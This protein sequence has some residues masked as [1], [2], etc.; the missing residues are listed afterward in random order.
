MIIIGRKDFI[1]LKRC[2]FIIKMSKISFYRK[3]RP[4]KFEDIIGQEPVIET[5]QGAIKKNKI[6][7]AYIFSGPRGTGKTSTARILAKSLNCQSKI[8]PC[9]KCKICQ[10]I[11]N[12]NSLD[13]I[14][15]DA[16]SHRGIEEIKEIISKINFAPSEGE[17]KIFIIDEAHMLTKEAFNV[18][19]KTLEEPPA[20]AIFIL[21]TT[22]IHKIIPTIISRCQGLDFKKLN[23]EQIKKYLK[24]IVQKEKISIDENALEMLANAADGSLRDA[25]SLLDQVAS[26]SDKKVTL[27]NVQFSLGLVLTDEIINL[28]LSIIKNQPQ[29]AIKIISQIADSGYDL[30]LFLKRII[31][32][33][34]RMYLIQLGSSEISL[35][36][37]EAKFLHENSQQLSIFNLTKM[38]KILSDAESNIS[39]SYIPQLAIEL[40]IIEMIQIFTDTD[41]KQNLQHLDNSKYQV[42]KNIPD[43]KTIK[44]TKQNFE[45]INKNQDKG[46]KTKISL[47]E[48][49][50]KWLEF[51]AEVKQE[52]HSLISLLSFTAPCKIKNHK[53]KIITKYKF[54]AQKLSEIS[55]RRILETVFTNFYHV[56]ARLEFDQVSQKTRELFDKQYQ[57]IKELEQREEQELLEN[58]KDVFG[59]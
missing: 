28:C 19:L 18:L 31:D 20:H 9:N 13:V 54:S 37:N 52:N 3:W 49:T 17:Y 27:E 7:H 45:K 6:A 51:L 48:I 50:Q 53:I 46:Q 43:L 38:I 58:T 14:E 25:A 1:N 2:F 44:K 26:I 36:E 15:L 57:K 12:S 5:L 10:E 4:Q 16:A 11:T 29:I 55:K 35:L 47:K 8:K 21:A 30:N 42:A 41:K 34:R 32:F 33:L 22:E 39:E 40:A 24:M 23:N 56:S 59:V